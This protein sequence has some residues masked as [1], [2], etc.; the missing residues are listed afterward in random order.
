M[1]KTG[2]LLEQPWN[3][4]IIEGQKKNKGGR[5]GREKWWEGSNQQKL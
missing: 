1:E 3:T 2:K 4:Y 5:E